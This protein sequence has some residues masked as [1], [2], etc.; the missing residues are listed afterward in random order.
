MNGHRTRNRNR[1]LDLLLQAR[2]QREESW[3]GGQDEGLKLEVQLQ[4]RLIGGINQVEAVKSNFEE[5]PAK[6][7]D[8]D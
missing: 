1:G 2:Y 5:R 8:P 6:Y 4:G 7:V 3:H